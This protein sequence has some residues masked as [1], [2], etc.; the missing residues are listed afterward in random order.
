MSSRNTITATGTGGSSAVQLSGG[1]DWVLQVT[2][3]SWGNADLQ[4]SC[5]GGT[6]FVDVVDAANGSVVNFTAN[7]A[8]AVK[9][10]LSYRLDVNSYTSAI[11]LVAQATGY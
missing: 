11:T 6:T 3:S 5:D 7:K 10:G 2:C 1:G 8:L 4:C 9:G